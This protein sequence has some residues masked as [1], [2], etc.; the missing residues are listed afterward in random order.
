MRPIILCGIFFT[1]ILN[2]NNWLHAPPPCSLI[3]AV[4]V[5]GRSYLN[6]TIAYKFSPAH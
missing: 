6:I 3:M 2:Y 1:F 4:P 5:G